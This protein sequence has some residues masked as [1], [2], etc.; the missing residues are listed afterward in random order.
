M[1]LRDELIKLSKEKVYDKY[2]SLVYDTKDYEKI[3]RS[4]M[5]DEII[6]EYN[7]DNYLYNIF[8]EKELL[9]LKELDNITFTE[10]IMDKYFWEITTLYRKCIFSIDD[11]QI[12]EEQKDN[13]KK[14][15]EF[16]EKHKDIKGTYD[17][18]IIFMI[19]TVEVYAQVI[20]D[21]LVNMVSDG[22]MNELINKYN[23]S[24]RYYKL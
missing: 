9:F 12:Y 14:S 18:L 16:Y 19:S 11:L 13:V 15:L 8:T 23:N 20:K 2:Q 4:K 24:T 5:I 21:N 7:D 1:K 22:N 3:T 10:E 17:E 6:K